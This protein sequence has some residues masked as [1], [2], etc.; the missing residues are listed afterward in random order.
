MTI[1]KIAPQLDSWAVAQRQFDLAA[2]RL[3]LDAGLRAVLREP[4]RELTVTFPVHMDDG[5][6]RV[7][8]G[9]RVQHNLG[10]GPAKGGLRYHQDVNLNE[11]RALAMWMSW[12]CAVVGIPYGGGKGG[13]RVDPKALS[14]A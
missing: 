6:V 10:R 2:D 13:V 7:F 8:E 3:G 5:S 1:S 9:F 11:V 12:K 4:R 14:I